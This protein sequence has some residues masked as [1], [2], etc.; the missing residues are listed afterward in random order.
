MFAV[1]GWSVSASS[2][3]TQVETEVPKAS[4]KAT[5]NGQSA[6]NERKPR[7]RKRGDNGAEVTKDNVGYLWKKYV[8]VK[9]SADDLA[10]GGNDDNKQAG[11]GW[12]EP[13]KNKRRGK[14]KNIA[15]GSQN[16]HKAKEDIRGLG[17]A[18]DGMKVV[19]TAP[20]Y[21]HE[22]S[23]PNQEALTR[24]QERTKAPY[25]Q[26][27]DDIEE[28]KEVKASQQADG[29]LPPTRPPASTQAAPT[30]HH[31]APAHKTMENGPLMIHEPKA[32]ALTSKKIMHA[33]GPLPPPGFTT[34]ITAVPPP[35]KP[36]TL[37]PLQQKMAAKL[38]S[39]RFRHLNQ[40]LYTSSSA[41]AKKLFSDTPEAYES[42]HL[43][44]R[45][46]VS[47]WP[48]NP[49][50]GFISDLKY[51]GALKVPTQK[52]LLREKRKEAM[53]RRKR[54]EYKP[55]GSTNETIGRKL[56][57]LPRSKDMVCR[58]I[59]LGC[60]DAHLAASLQ[61]SGKN[62]KNK[63]ENNNNNN[64]VRLNLE[65]QSF[66]LAKG[67]TPNSHLVSVADITNL[68]PAGVGDASVDI[69]ICCLSLMGTNWVDVVDEC[70]RVVREGGEV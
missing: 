24:T 45:A 14:E 30:P 25:K 9:S 52:H 69:A 4:G 26:R 13:K 56:D 70:A 57:V 53:A 48:T 37:T 29:K 5:Q 17:L 46:Q 11:E 7:K 41:N 59:D 61:P 33:K 6:E 28:N 51:R 18:T 22:A 40:S 1:P 39:A 34:T 2:L 27:K 36:S 66:D 31:E 8:E 58:I 65:I 12:K 42:Y 67:V 3:K 43:G 16:D 15:E 62:K 47:S 49:I 10:I 44:F 50:E 21:A 35:V 54:K 63:N 64:N 68:R 32:E 38:T 23:S 20:E 19:T 60:G 55:H